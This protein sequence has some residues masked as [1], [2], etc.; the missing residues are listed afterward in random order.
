MPETILIVDD[1]EPV[2]K[3]FLDWL[4]TSG[5]SVDVHAVP[6]AESALLF[7]NTHSVDL[8]VLDWNLGTGSDGLRLL[9]DLAE[10]HPDIIA[11]LVTGFAHQ[12]T[13]LEAL[14]MGVRDY[15]DKN[16]DLTRESFLQAVR[17]Q[18]ERI[19]PAKLH[20]QV[21]E[22]LRQFRESVEKILPLVRSA[23]AMNDPVPLPDAVR[24]LFRFL[25]RTTGS[26][27]GVFLGRA[28]A[29]DGTERF[30]AFAPDGKPLPV[31]TVPFNR[32]LAATVLSMNEP[33]A[34]NAADLGSL[35]AVEL[36]SFERNRQSILA[37]PVP[38]APGI[39]VVL[40]LFDKP[41]GFTAADRK[42]VD[43]AA[44]FSTELLRQAVAERQTQQVLIGAVEA[45]LKASEQVSVVLPAERADTL[46]TPLPA[47]VMDQLRAG[48]DASANAVVDAKTSLELAEAV[49]EL[50]VRHGPTAVRH[51]VRLVQSVRELLDETSGNMNG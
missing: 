18:L 48:L 50:A 41:G 28:V 21:T 11:I 1:E 9:E 24:N 46:Q 45:A 12:A 51:C 31:P 4:R 6:D 25:I 23:T 7:A 13:P 36:Q 30:L 19:I 43:A 35:G 8:A 10:F 16:Q 26:T 33:C 22:G 49:R 42:F 20:R 37:A 2:R 40:E 34:M 5:L 14:R 27:D 15:L 39:H 47:A 17:K 3:T 32:S 29:P 38:V 44:D